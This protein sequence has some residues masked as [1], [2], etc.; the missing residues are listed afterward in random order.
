MQKHSLKDFLDKLSATDKDGKYKELLKKMIKLDNPNLQ[1]VL[2]FILKNNKHGDY[3][4]LLNVI[5]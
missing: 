2:Q 3:D 5:N 1:D 4:D